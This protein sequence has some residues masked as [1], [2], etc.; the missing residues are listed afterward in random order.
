MCYHI[1]R[2]DATFRIGMA[3]IAKIVAV[4]RRETGVN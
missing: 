1:E 3:I 2:S 4:A